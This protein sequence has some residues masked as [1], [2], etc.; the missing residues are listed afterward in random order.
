MNAFH[1]HVKRDLL[2]RIVFED[3]VGFIRPDMLSAAWSSTRNCLCDS[4][5]G[6]PPNRLRDAGAPASA[7]RALSHLWRYAN[8]FQTA[9]FYD[10]WRPDATNMPD[11]AVRSHDA[12]RDIKSRNLPQAFA[13]SAMP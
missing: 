13:S 4:T 1:D 11:F 6:L 2:R 10:G 7:T 8:S 5:F 12:L 3:A 9:G